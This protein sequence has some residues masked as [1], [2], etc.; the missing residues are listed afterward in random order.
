[1]IFSIGSFYEFLSSSEIP[2]SVIA[3]LLISSSKTFYL[4]QCFWLLDF[5][6]SLSIES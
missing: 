3:S 2:S 5:F 4:L 1:L 6:G